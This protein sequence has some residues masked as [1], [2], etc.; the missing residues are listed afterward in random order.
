M[1]T[2]SEYR[3]LARALRLRAALADSFAPGVLLAEVVG[4]AWRADPLLVAE[5]LTDL[6]ADCLEVTAPAGAAADNGSEAVRW[7]MRPGARHKVFAAAGEAGRG[8]L[9]ELGKT[10]I[11]QALLGQGAYD[12]QALAAL[13]AAGDSADAVALAR[14]VVALD[15]AGPT[16]PGHRQLVALR[17]RLNRALVLAEG[18]GDAA[19]TAAWADELATLEVWLAAPQAAAPLRVLHVLG[20]PGVGKTRLLELFLRRQMLREAAGPVT[21]RL[22]FTRPALQSPRGRPLF[23]ELLRQIGDSLPDR[24]QALRDLRS[25]SAEQWAWL[26]GEGGEA[27]VPAPLARAI[28]AE[29][30]L[31][32]RVLLIVLDA[33]E[34]LQDL[35]ETRVPRLFEQLDLLAGQGAAIAVIAA[36]PAG[37]FETAVG[38]IGRTLTLAGEAAAGSAPPFASDRARRLWDLLSAWRPGTELPQIAAQ[39]ALAVP[40]ELERA[41]PVPARDALRQARGQRSRLGRPI[42]AD[43]GPAAPVL[44]PAVAVPAGLVRIPAGSGARGQAGPVWIL[45]DPAGL[46]ASLWQGLPATPAAVDPRALRDLELMLEQ[47]DLREAGSVLATGFPGPV[48]LDGRAGLLVLVQQWAAGRWALVRQA[49][50]LIPAVVLAQQLRAGPPFLARALLDICAE[51]DGMALRRRLAR[52]GPRARALAV[53]RQAGAAGL[54][55]GTLELLVLAD[56]PGPEIPPEIARAAALLAGSLPRVPPALVEEAE[57]QAEGLRRSLGLGWQAATAGAG[58]G[59]AAAARRLAPLNPCGMVLRR[60]I[61]AEA[62]RDS[63]RQPGPWLEA[64][65]ERLAALAATHA[66]EVMG[67]A[68]LGGQLHPGPAEVAL[69]FARLGLAAEWSSGAAFFHPVADLPEI[70]RAA[71]RWR[72]TTNGLWSLAGAPPAGWSGAERGRGDAGAEALA[73]RL[74]AAGPEAWRAALADWAAGG[75]ATIEPGQALARLDRRYDAAREAAGAVGAGAGQVGAALGVLQAAGLAAV[76]AAPLAVAASEGQTLAAVVAAGAGN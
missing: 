50:G 75:A 4:A 29:V 28:A 62:R 12:P 36:G 41:L 1:A 2:D 21:V 27:R 26:D 68:A 66:P 19:A 65:R 67:A 33:V 72:R 18:A 52:A 63:G 14:V 46:R 57:A 54:T 55:G 60:L 3:D 24:A 16:A 73:F 56:L 40:A 49:V 11:G 51:F 61:A 64:R 39:P 22:D 15:R 10:P 74:A 23:E 37:V 71:E 17:H 9:A 13:A 7:L 32:G 43:G 20:A 70:A 5:L 53:I 44:P 48:A 25:R 58:D 59:L 42:A 8:S 47:G 76:I 31:A 38:R 69:A 30:A 34:R 35:G 6:G 45:P